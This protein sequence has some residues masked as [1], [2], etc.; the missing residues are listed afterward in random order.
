[1]RV[2][3]EFAIKGPPFS[4]NSAKSQPRKHNNWKRT[5]GNAA[6]EQWNRDSPPGYVLPLDMPLEVTITTYFTALQRDVDNV[7]KPIL[8]GMKGAI[9][10]DDAEIYKVT[11]QRYNLN[12]PVVIEG[13]SLLLAQALNANDELVYV[14]LSWELSEESL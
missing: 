3:F 11:S 13:P 14:E 9:Y 6:K 10:V 8:D 2:S 4:V 5:V 1:M 7:I 12:V